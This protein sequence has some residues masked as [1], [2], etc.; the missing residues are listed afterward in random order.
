MI[1][2][3]TKEIVGGAVIVAG[4]STVAVASEATLPLLAALG[5][6]VALGAGLYLAISAPRRKPNSANNGH[7]DHLAGISHD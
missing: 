3:M 1:R 4:A 5:G 6:V 2:S 7:S